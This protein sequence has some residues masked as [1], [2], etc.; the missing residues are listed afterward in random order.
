MIL[1]GHHDDGRPVRDQ[2]LVPGSGAR[3]RPRRTGE[4]SAGP[5]AAAA[6]AASRDQPRS[7]AAMARGSAR[8]TRRAHVGLPSRSRS[9]AT[10]VI[11]SCS[12]RDAQPSSSSSSSSG[13]GTSGKPTHSSG[14]PRAITASTRSGA[15]AATRSEV[16]APIDQPQSAAEATPSSSRTART[17]VAWQCRLY[18]AGSTGRSLRPW[19]RA[20]MRITR[21]PVPQAVD[22]PLQTP[23]LRAP[24]HPVQEH[25]RG[26][27]ALRLVP[28]PDPGTSRDRHDDTPRVR[29][30]R[31][32]RRKRARSGAPGP[33]PEDPP[34]R[35][36]DGSCL[37]PFD[38]AGWRRYHSASLPRTRVIPS[39]RR[40]PRSRGA[41]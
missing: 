32:S 8:S 18:S 21:W 20:S 25:D 7:Q 28:D 35:T 40:S 26:P 11:P 38:T 37:V 17:S 12:K 5:G 22:V 2:R 23:G 31:G 34:L 1:V 13:A 15:S 19:P 36:S 29:P 6:P 27:L 41:V 9:A 14:A 3:A 16:P 4:A 33:E 10:Q 30:S 39:D 24:H